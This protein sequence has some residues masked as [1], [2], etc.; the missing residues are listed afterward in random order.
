M[1]S[2][3]ILN[4]TAKRRPY[5]RSRYNYVEFNTLNGLSNLARPQF[6]AIQDGAAIDRKVDFHLMKVSPVAI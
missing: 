2:A 3:R 5:Y 6:I 4:S 1:T